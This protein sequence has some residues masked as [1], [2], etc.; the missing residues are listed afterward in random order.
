[1][2]FI[3]KTNT[4]SYLKVWIEQYLVINQKIQNLLEMEDIGMETYH[5]EQHT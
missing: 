2:F 4:T 5:Q 1:M 3:E